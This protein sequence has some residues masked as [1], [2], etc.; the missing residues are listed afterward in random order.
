M[1]IKATTFGSGHEAVQYAN[2]FGGKAILLDCPMVVSEDDA[3]RIA[4]AG[5]EMAY[6]CDVHGQLVTIPVN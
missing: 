1:T 3:N 2:L 4:A 5:V 6:L